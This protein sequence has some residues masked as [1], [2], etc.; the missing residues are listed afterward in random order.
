MDYRL[1]NRV[2]FE[3]R[4]TL[5]VNARKKAPTTPFSFRDEFFIG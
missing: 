4:T 5:Q 2:L 1:K 3:G